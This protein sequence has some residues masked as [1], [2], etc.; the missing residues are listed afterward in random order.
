MSDAV[1]N[2]SQPSDDF[3]VVG[4]RENRESWER[5]LTEDRQISEADR[6]EMFRMKNFNDALP[7]L[8]AIPGFHVC[9]L[10]TANP[11]DPIQQ[12]VRLGYVPVKPEEVPGAE[13][14]T[15][16]TGEYAGLVGVNEMVAFK[17]PLRLY[18]M[19]MQE[20]HHEAPRREEEQLTAAADRLR[21]TAEQ[22]GAAL[23]EDDGMTD[24]REQHPSKGKFES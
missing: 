23:I 3:D 13:Y 20:A 18:E 8:P 7:D 17:L 10:T 9:W 6:L 22:A 11:R 4:H 16:K 24:L 21:A 19:Y 14:A 2:T 1:N 15:I 5:E 12:R